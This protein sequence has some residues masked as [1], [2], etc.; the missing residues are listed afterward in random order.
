[1]TP[2]EVDYEVIFSGHIKDKN[3]INEQQ[4]KSTSLKPVDIYLFDIKHGDK[5]WE[6]FTVIFQ[7][8]TVVMNF[9]KHAI[10]LKN[11]DSK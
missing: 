10:T 4:R 1:M 11:T 5:D 7:G 6:A 3:F 9:G 8:K 2:I